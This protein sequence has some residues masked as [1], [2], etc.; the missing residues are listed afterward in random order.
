MGFSRQEYWSGVLLP[1]P[2]THKCTDKAN[3]QKNWKGVYSWHGSVQKDYS[4]SHSFLILPFKWFYLFCFFFF[5]PWKDDAL[6]N[7]E[8]NVIYLFIYLVPFLLQASMT[9]T[10][11]F[12]SLLSSSDLGIFWGGL[13]CLLS[14]F[15]GWRGLRRDSCGSSLTA[16][17]GPLASLPEWAWGPWVM[18]EGCCWLVYID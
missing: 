7:L 10:I 13:R 2:H 15:V 3:Q 4:W 9:D 14:W 16:A 6:S 1:S 5:P 17:G 11:V 12:F 8:V 18:G